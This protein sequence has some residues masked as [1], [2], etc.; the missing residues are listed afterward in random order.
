MAEKSIRQVGLT[1]RK[2][3]DTF[4]LW[5]GGGEVEKERRRLVLFFG[6]HRVTSAASLSA[7]VRPS[8]G[9]VKDKKNKELIPPG[10]S[11]HPRNAAGHRPRLWCER[12]ASGFFFLV[13]S[14]SNGNSTQDDGTKKRRR[15]RRAPRSRQPPDFL[16]VSFSSF[17]GRPI[18]THTHTHIQTHVCVCVWGACRWQR[19]NHE[20]RRKNVGV[21]AK[22]E[23]EKKRNRRVIRRA[24]GRR[25]RPCGVAGRR[26]SATWA[27]KNPRRISGIL[28]SIRP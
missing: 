21:E 23:E 2:V 7:R 14:A 22:K 26:R 5:G 27:A 17:L 16:F 10:K 28:P 25:R 4:S 13:R 15:R 18:H 8:S 9:V 3:T 6:I 11:L 19:R 24:E 1:G 20:R 12:V